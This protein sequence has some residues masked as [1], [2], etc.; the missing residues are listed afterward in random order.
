MILARGAFGRGDERFGR[1]WR[2]SLG[3]YARQGSDGEDANR[4]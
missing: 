3:M 2:R 1:T 4:Q